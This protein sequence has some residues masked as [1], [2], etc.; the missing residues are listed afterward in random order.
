MDISFSQAQA[1][2]HAALKLAADK[3]VAVA[4]AVVDAHGEL[5][6]YGKM[7]G[8]AFHAGVLAQNKAYT[9]ARDRQPTANLA[10]WAQQTGKDLGYWSDP[11]FTGIGGGMPIAID[12]QV[13]G[14]IGISGMSEEDDASLAQAAIDLGLS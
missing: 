12:G 9:A 7:D 11:K 8:V 14:A 5:V 3:Q 4:V 10:Q 2:Y 13:V 1:V 6:C